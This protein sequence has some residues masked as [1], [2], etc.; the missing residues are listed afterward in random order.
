MIRS[1]DPMQPLFIANV[2]AFRHKDRH[3][4]PREISFLI[5]RRMLPEA[6]CSERVMRNRH[7]LPKYPH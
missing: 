7:D 6:T 2:D 3:D 1:T 5:K 4:K